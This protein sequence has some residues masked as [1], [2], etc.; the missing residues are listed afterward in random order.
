MPETRKTQKIADAAD[1]PNLE[2]APNNAEEPAIIPQGLVP[3]GNVPCDDD[4]GEDPPRRRRQIELEVSSSSED[5]SD[6]AE[7]EE[8]IDQVDFRRPRVEKV[9]KSPV[10]FDSVGALKNA[11]EARKASRGCW[12]K[13]IKVRGCQRVI[14]RHTTISRCLPV[15]VLYQPPSPAPSPPQ[16]R[17]YSLRASP[18]SKR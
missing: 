5:D 7:D 10:S 6:S 11:L 16:K 2:Q 13:H 4:R 9:K 14:F 8:L 12:S 17:S 15:S 3:V 1:A 18:R